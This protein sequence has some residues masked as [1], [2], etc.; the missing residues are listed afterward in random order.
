M[1]SVNLL[2]FRLTCEG[3]KSVCSEVSLIANATGVNNAKCAVCIPVRA[4]LGSKL[5]AGEHAKWICGRGI[6]SLSL[7]NPV[8][9]K[10][11]SICALIELGLCE[12]KVLV[13]NVKL[14]IIDIKVIIEVDSGGNFSKHTYT[15]CKLKKEVPCGCILHIRTG[16]HVSKVSELTGNRNL[17]HIKSKDIVS[18]HILVKINS[19]ISDKVYGCSIFNIT[20]P[21]ELTV[22]TGCH[23]EVKAIFTL[24][25]HVKCNAAA[26]RF[27]ISEANADLN[28]LNTC[29]LVTNEYIAADSTVVIIFEAK[30]NILISE[31][32]RLVVV[33]CS[34]RKLSV[35]TIYCIHM[36]SG[37]VNVLGN[38]NVHLCCTYNFTIMHHINFNSTVS[39]TCEYTILGNSCKTVITNRPSISLGKFNLVT[40][41][42]DTLCSKLH[43]STNSRVLV[44][45]LDHCMIELSRAGSG[46]YHKKRGGYRTCITVGRSVNNAK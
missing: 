17:S 29:R 43:G 35:C 23:A 38:N 16:K 39:K 36:C 25:E 5:D 11:K 31:S 18:C 14:A 26:Y 46:R 12:A 15:L 33:A 27:I 7:V 1:K 3:I 13:T 44:L 28:N 9:S 32:N 40:G 6:N 30:L 21:C 10:C 20:K 22:T 34:Y 41:R 24:L 42:A 45:T 4:I 8:K 19:C 37:E 2:V